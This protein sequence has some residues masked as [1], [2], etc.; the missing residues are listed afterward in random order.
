MRL[1]NTELALWR[2]YKMMAR[3]M[4]N[5]IDYSPYKP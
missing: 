2:A 1:Q 4:L 3:L 5:F